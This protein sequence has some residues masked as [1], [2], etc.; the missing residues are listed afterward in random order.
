M[1]RT[2]MGAGRDGAAELRER[3]TAWRRDRYPRAR[4]PPELWA[5]AAAWARQL[6]THRAARVLGVSV[7]SLRAHAQD[8]GN[9]GEAHVGFVEMPGMHRVDGPGG[10][11]VEVHRADGKHLRV[12]LGAWQAVDVAAVVCAFGCGPSCSR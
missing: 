10:A 11:V 6:G 4:L 3:I 9:G 12:H 8:Q 1:A 5:Q 2:S 7:E